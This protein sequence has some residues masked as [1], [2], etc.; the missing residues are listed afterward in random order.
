MIEH[1]RSPN[2]DTDELLQGIYWKIIKADFKNVLRHHDKWQSYLRHFKGQRRCEAPR[3]FSQSEYDEIGTKCR[4]VLK[5]CMQAPFEVFGDDI[6]RMSRELGLPELLLPEVRSTIHR[7]A[8]QPLARP[9]VHF[10]NGQCELLEQNISS[11]L[12]G[13]SHQYMIEYFHDHPVMREL[14]KEFRLKVGS[15][16]TGLSNYMEK[17]G[18]A[19]KNVALLDEPMKKGKVPDI[20]NLHSL[21]YLKERGVFYHDPYIEGRDFKVKSG[22]VYLGD[23]KIDVLYRVNLVKFLLQHKHM[24]K[25]FLA[26][27]EGK[28]EMFSDASE[29]LFLDKQIMALLSDPKLNGFLKPAEKKMLDSFLP[30]TRLLRSGTTDFD[31]AEIDMATLLLRQRQK[32]ILKPGYGVSGMGVTIGALTAP[33]EWN[34]TVQRALKDKC[35]VA[36]TVFFRKPHVSPAIVNRTLVEYHNVSVDGAWIIDDKHI[37]M[38]CSVRGFYRNST[39]RTKFQRSA[40]IIPGYIVENAP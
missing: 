3:F 38:L 37:G 26:A 12:G 32:F 33:V 16:Y 25:L 22:G 34:R 20:E 27:A 39:K 18:F 30:W 10:S 2:G 1:K 36:Q 13:W 35:W 5:K 14:Q 4:L 28:V 40:G 9:E 15:L 31:G 6:E 7:G 8:V 17:A 24:R 29:I 11:T 21:R 23:E 19:A